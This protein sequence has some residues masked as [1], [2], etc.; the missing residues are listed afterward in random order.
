MELISHNWKTWS[1]VAWWTG[2]A[3]LQ[4]AGR[5][6][7]TF[8]CCSW[9]SPPFSGTASTKALSDGGHVGSLHEGGLHILMGDGAV[10]F[11]SEN[12]NFN[13]RVNLSRIAD[14]N[15]IGEF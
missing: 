4:D 12:V 8:R 7:N 13:T 10:R 3:T 6:P 1:S 11:L 15:V 9:S 2:G 5:P 14:G